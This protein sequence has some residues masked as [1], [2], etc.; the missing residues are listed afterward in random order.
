MGWMIKGRFCFFRWSL[1]DGAL[2][3]SKEFQLAVVLVFTSGFL[4]QSVRFGSVV[5]VIAPRREIIL[6]GLF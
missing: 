1:R 4:L 3:L 6:V 2:F 5:V